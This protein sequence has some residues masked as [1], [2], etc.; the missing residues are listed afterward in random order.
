M[1]RPYGEQRI[2]VQSMWLQDLRRG[3]WV[4]Q[5]LFRVST[6][7]FCALEGED[8]SPQQAKSHAHVESWL[9]AGKRIPNMQRDTHAHMIV[10]ASR[11]E[12]RIVQST[13]VLGI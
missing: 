9:L 3:D 6:R 5:A 4:T 10:S 8:Q 11:G 1:A 13:V 7:F 12:H 2:S